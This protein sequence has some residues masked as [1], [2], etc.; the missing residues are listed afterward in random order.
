MISA[1]LV[2]IKNILDKEEF[3]Y[4]EITQEENLMKIV[5]EGSL[6][7]THSKFE[8]ILEDA[9]YKIVGFK[10]NK[11]PGNDEDSRY[12]TGIYVLDVQE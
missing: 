12:Y 3:L 2:I 8:N 9:G 7:G 10:K 5:L 1:A 6:E 11:A 4:D